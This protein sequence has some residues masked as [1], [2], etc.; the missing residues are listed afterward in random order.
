MEID[1]LSTL[2]EPLIVDILRRLS[3]NKEAATVLDLKEAGKTAVLSKR[4]RFLWTE[5]PFVFRNDSRNFYE[6]RSFVATVSAALAARREAPLRSLFVGF[7]F[8]KRFASDVDSWVGFAGER[9]AKS[10]SLSLERN[11]GL[12]VLPRIIYS[13]PSLSSLLL[14]NS[15]GVGTTEEVTDR[16][17]GVDAGCS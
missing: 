7:N 13:L 5:L 14:R 11:H 8:D 12:Y 2:P 4:W 9:R 6:V 16:V 15:G 1:R 17:R 10:L 3:F